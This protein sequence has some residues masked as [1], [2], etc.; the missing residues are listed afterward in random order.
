MP[1]CNSCGAEIEVGVKFCPKCGE[2]V[3]AATAASGAGN[4][5]S[6]S[7]PA[8]ASNDNV[9]AA[10]SYLLIPAII[11]LVVE[12]YN[13]NRF[14]R[15]H[16]FQSI[17]FAV[18]SIAFNIAWGILATILSFVGVGFVLW[19]LSPLISLLL[20]AV[21]II[22]LIKAFQGQEYKLPWIGEMAAKQA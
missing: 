15:F 21:W 14:I 12:P 3:D 8:A 2:A 22:L 20:L 16:S 5:S 10:L 19:M 18:A 17:F 13:K 4:P 9:M 11:F 7:V 6:G 1:F